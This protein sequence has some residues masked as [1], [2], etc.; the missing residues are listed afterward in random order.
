MSTISE[1]GL[2]VAPENAGGSGADDSV[3]LYQQSV[4]FYRLLRTS[5]TLCLL[6]AIG[7]SGVTKGEANF[8]AVSSG[9][10][11]AWSGLLPSS[12]S[13]SSS[14]STNPRRPHSV[15]MQ[16]I[17]VQLFFKNLAQPFVTPRYGTYGGGDGKEDSSGV[18]SFHS[19]QVPLDLNGTSPPPSSLSQNRPNNNRGGGGNHTTVDK[20]S[21]AA[22]HVEIVMALSNL[23]L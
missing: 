15:P 10:I 6:N 19:S 5:S 9:Q 2:T 17:P 12:T 18:L 21:I 20:V 13:S 16:V 4:E 22:S 8:T 14:S 1:N 3:D 23:L 7:G 11:Q